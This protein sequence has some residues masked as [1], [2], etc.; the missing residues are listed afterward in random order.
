[1]HVGSADPSGQCDERLSPLPLSEQPP[2]LAQ[3]ANRQG[4]Q[5][6]LPGDDPSQ[7]YAYSRGPVTGPRS[8]RPHTDTSHETRISFGLTLPV[9]P[10]V[11]FVRFQDGLLTGERFGYDPNGLLQQGRLHAAVGRSRTPLNTS[12]HGLRER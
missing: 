8:H 4:E 6:G 11:V 5:G 7:G 9:M 12:L 3:H 1:V 2:H 10:V